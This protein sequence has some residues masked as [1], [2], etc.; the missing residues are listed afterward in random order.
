MKSSNETSINVVLRL[1][2]PSLEEQCRNKCFPLPQ[3]FII[4]VSHRYWSYKMNL[5]FQQTSHL[6][7]FKLLLRNNSEKQVNFSILWQNMIHYT[8]ATRTLL[9]QSCVYFNRVSYFLIKHPLR[10]KSQGFYKC[11]SDK[12]SPISIK[13]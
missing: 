3:T 10:F 1:H 5:K 7:P 12:S 11:A 9:S 13:T 2:P 6:I 4:G 8:A